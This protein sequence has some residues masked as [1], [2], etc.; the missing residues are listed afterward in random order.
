MDLGRKAGNKTLLLDYQKPQAC[1]M[2]SVKMTMWYFDHQTGC[3]C[4][5]T[6]INGDL[7][8]CDLKARVLKLGFFHQNECLLN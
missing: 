7:Q 4:N 2:K 1:K 5:C 6:S 8:V 3:S